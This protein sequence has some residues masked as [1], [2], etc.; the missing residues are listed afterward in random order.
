ML[1]AEIVL[2]ARSRTVTIEPDPL[3]TLAIVTIEGAALL[4]AVEGPEHLNCLVNEP[5]TGSSRSC[6]RTRTDIGWD[7]GGAFHGR[8]PHRADLRGRCCPASGT[9]IVA[10]L[11]R[12]ERAVLLGLQPDLGPDA[13]EDRLSL[14]GH[15]FLRSAFAVSELATASLSAVAL[16]LSELGDRLGH[17]RAVEVDR[18]LCD[19]W[20][21]LHV[22]PIGWTAPSA[23]DPL[24][25]VFATVEGSWI[26]THA[27]APR[28]RSALLTVLGCDPDQQ[29]VARAIRSWRAEELETAIIERGG[30]AAAL[31]TAADWKRSPA[32]QAVTAEPLVRAQAGTRRD[33][34]SAWSPTPTRPLRGLRVLDLTRVIAGPACTQVLAGLGAD[35][36]RID[37]PG[38]DEP[39][40]LPLVMWNKRSARLDAKEPAGA[41]RLRDLLAEADVLVHGYRAGAL[42]RLGLPFAERQRIRP[43]LIE[44]S[45]RAYGWSGPW[46]ERRGFDSLAQ[47]ATGIAHTGMVS[48]GRREPLSLPVQALD[49][50]TGYLA[51]ACAL[52][53]LVRRVDTGAGSS[54]HLSLARTAHE[55]RRLDRAPAVDELSAEAREPPSQVVSTPHGQ[56]ALASSPIRVGAA[57]LDH[58][59]VTTT[60]G[61]HRPEWR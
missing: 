61:I 15:G 33:G 28:H 8:R 3:A 41:A 24:S 53:G 55:L 42:D 29:A 11:T 12:G 16:A 7:I 45:E 36:L 30:A 27:N 19:A 14:V 34:P 5:S 17:D 57:A 44:V 9:G 21:G 48:S 56:V 40:V 35:V 37:P 18:E 59:R 13:F 31:R 60:L 51:A 22:R 10:V 52:T 43:G 2:V 20:F 4:A 1:D 47:F 6:G 23:W 32:G 38:W 39:A 49:W 26:R 46:A 58:S 50:A 25:G 54:W